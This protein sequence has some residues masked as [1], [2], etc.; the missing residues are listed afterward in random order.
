MINFFFIILQND[1][2]QHLQN[3]SQQPNNFQGN[4]VSEPV[5]CYA[6]GYGGVPKQMPPAPCPL[7]SSG[8]LSSHTAMNSGN[9][10]HTTLPNKAYPLQPPTP[11]VSNQFSYI[12]AESQQRP[13]PWGSFSSIG[14]RFQYAHG[15]QGGNLCGERNIRG[16]IQHEHPE[17]GRFS[18]VVN[19]GKDLLWN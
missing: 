16:T 4:L 11:T 6:H 5:P 8:L 15:P 9:N 14:D 1:Q 10:F 7:G 17:R 3:V 12:Q 18:P 2:S 19:T 13:Q